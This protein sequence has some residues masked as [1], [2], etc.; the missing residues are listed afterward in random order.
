M[1]A[2]LPVAEPAVTRTNGIAAP[3]VDLRRGRKHS[4]RRDALTLAD[5]V[6]LVATRRI[7]TNSLNRLSLATATSNQA[8]V[9]F[10]MLLSDWFIG[11]SLTNGAGVTTK[12][13][14]SQRES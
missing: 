4:Q 5:S 8:V 2:T 10:G 14:I 7:I 1:T 11:D 13:G 9:H 3:L 6:S 12:P